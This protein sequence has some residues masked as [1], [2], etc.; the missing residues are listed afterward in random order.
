MSEWPALILCDNP[1][2]SELLKGNRAGNVA[3]DLRKGLEGVC[4]VKLQSK[5]VQEFRESIQ[6]NVVVVIM[7]M[8]IEMSPQERLISQARLHLVQVV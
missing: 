4:I 6:I 8:K 1:P 5:L 7:I 3:V 2:V